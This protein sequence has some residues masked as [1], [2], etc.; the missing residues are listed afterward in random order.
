MLDLAEGLKL[1]LQSLREE[2]EGGSI[3]C[4]SK[5]ELR[6]LIVTQEIGTFIHLQKLSEAE[7]FEFL[8]QRT[9]A[10]VDGSIATFGGGYPG[11][12]SLLQAGAM[13]MTRNKFLLGDA[14]SPLSKKDQV[15]IH[16][17]KERYQISE[18]EAFNRYKDER[19]ATLEIMS[20]IQLI[21]QEQP[22]LLM[23]DGGFVRYESKAGKVWEEYQAL[24]QR[25]QIL[26]VGIIEEVGTNFIAQALKNMGKALPYDRQLL[27]GVLAKGEALLLN[28]T[29]RQ[30]GYSGKYYSCFAR[31]SNHPSIIGCDLFASDRERLI[32][33]L[34]Y[35]YT[36]TIE[37][38]RGVPFWIDRIDHEIKLSYKETE[39]L[40]RQAFAPAW[41]EKFLVSQRSRR[42]I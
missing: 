42:D 19:L 25:L 22:A 36:N 30:K 20:A 26:S 12:V 18:E 3:H 6:Q 35:L 27:F 10:G 8:A 2:W 31:L 13:T 17:Y 5:E 33:L 16:D 34:R 23:F 37:T 38:S 40:I 28:P 7:L 21:Q 1:S 15:H 29:L 9:V 14:M 4:L 24:N 32:P 39:A 11:V 41:V